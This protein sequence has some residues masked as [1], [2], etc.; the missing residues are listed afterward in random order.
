MSQSHLT[1]KPSDKTAHKVLSFVALAALLVTLLLVLLQSPAQLFAATASKIVPLDKVT[2]AS[3]TSLLSEP[4]SASASDSSPATEVP[5]SVVDTGQ[6]KCYNATSE[7]TCP[8]TGAAFYGQDAQHTGHAASYVLSDNGMTVYDNI[9]GLT[10]ERSPDTNGDGSLTKTDKLSY[11]NAVAHCA[12]HSA[13]S[14]Q[15]YNDWRLPTIKEL[16]SL[17]DFR[18]T[19][20]SGYSGTDTSGLTPF[21]D[22]T[23]FQFAY[24]QTSAGERI[25]DSQYASNTEYVVNSNSSGKLFGVNFADGRIKGYD[26]VMPGGATKTFFVQCVR[27]NA[28]YG[29]NDFVDNGDQTITDNATNL[30]WAKSDSGVGLNWQSAL[31]WVQT[32]NAAN[33]LG[34]NDWRLPDAKE[35]Q[36]IVDYTRSPDTTASAAINPIFDATSFVNE[37]GQ[38]DWPWYWTSTT[39]ATYNGMGASAVY[40]AFGRAGGWQKSPPSATCYTLDDVHGAGAQRSD[41]KTSSG[42]VTMGTACNGGVAYGLGPQGDSQRAANYLRLV[43]DASAELAVTVSSFT[44]ACEADV[45]V[46]A[47][48]T[49]AVINSAGFNLWRSDSAGTPEIQL[50]ASS[51]AAHPSSSY[52][53]R[54]ETAEAGHLHY[55]WLEEVATSGTTALYEP[56]SVT[57]FN[58]PPIV[59]YRRLHLPLVVVR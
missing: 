37:D 46:I 57:C 16:Y 50:N 48:E 32:Q 52:Q 21:I 28:S 13:A 5:Y 11:P 47:W 10:W 30:M 22:T 49:V 41:P 27:G 18:G 56:V 44:A 51:I 20:P 24:G 38:T 25:I 34:H 2:F 9:T 39:H 7:A 15:G 26:L 6:S 55:Y 59:P 31:A 58:S 8:A 14:Y 12:A 42:L 1:N 19:D 35:L 40:L 33:Y 45:P 53:W 29:V 54:D 3:D 36:S 43:R 4:A 17:I 23:Y